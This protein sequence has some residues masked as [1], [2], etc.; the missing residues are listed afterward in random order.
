MHLKNF[1]FKRSLSKK[2]IFANIRSK[3]NIFFSSMK[4]F[5]Y[6]RL[7]FFSIVFFS[8]ASS[9]QSKNNAQRNHQFDFWIGDW[10]LTWNDTSKGS[11]N[12]TLEMNDFVV[13]E[14]FNDRVNNFSGW[15]WSVYDT[16]SKK[17]K[18]TW[19]DNQ[20]TYLDFTGEMRDN[21]MML[22]RS[23]TSKKGKLIKQRMIFYNITKNDFDWN[24]ENSVDEGASWK[25]SW[26]IHYHRRP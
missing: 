11:N 3:K 4:I 19:V 1:C 15:S 10:D 23:F 17:W 8:N 5:F 6:S 13:Y 24:W 2:S 12:V 22:E 14:H 18:Q 21:K 16:V 20:G 25:L 7:L 26:K 9:A